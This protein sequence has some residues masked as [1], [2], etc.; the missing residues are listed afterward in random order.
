MLKAL[1]K[2]Q[3]LEL[4]TFY[5]IDRKKG[6]RRSKTGVIGMVI[7]FAMLFIFLGGAF[8]MM[9]NT[10]TVVLDTGMPWLYFALMSI[11]SVMLGV[12]G[13][14]FNTYSALW[15]AR[16][17]E[18][19]LSMPIKPSV[20]LGVRMIGV[21]MMAALY[22]GLV[23]I[24][25]LIARILAGRL[26]VGVVVGSLLM[27]LAV[28]M[29]VV[30]LTTLLGWAVAM[31]SARFK[32]QSWLTVLLSVVFMG[33]YYFVCAQS[34]QF[35]ESLVLNSLRVGEIVRSWLYPFYLIGTAAEGSVSSMMI[36]LG[37]ILVLMA[38]LWAVM[39]KTF[40]GI[41]GRGGESGSRAVY[42]ERRMH[43]ASPLWALI[44]KE[45]K[46]FTSSAGYMLNCGIGLVFMLALAVIAVL[47][48]DMVTGML[49]MAAAMIPG[50][51]GLLATLA[52]A[53][54]CLMVS[55]TYISAPSVSLEGK[56]LWIAQTLPV[57]G[58]LV[59]KAKIV[60]HLMIVELPALITT[61]VLAY[62]LRI[63]MATVVLMALNVSLFV[64]LSAAAGVALNLKMP[65]FNWT[66]EMYVVKQSIPVLIILFGGFVL[67]LG[68]AGSAFLLR[69]VLSGAAF[70]ACSLVVLAAAST[71]VLM[72]VKMRGSKI[73][74]KL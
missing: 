54:V 55:T 27:A 3:I 73:F 10:L 68:I 11:L 22:E 26:T 71:S 46:H 72:W 12:F 43:R 4:N 8:F 65:D 39:S 47:K 29:I 40:I 60:M 67:A 20:I 34:S 28:L 69:N 64:L 2:K 35:I 5:F 50:F 51:K 1:L 58:W 36:V 59:L 61:F 52:V 16:D 32:N 44:R 33:A 23:M 24:P 6:T 31:I 38:V 13:S 74:E 30:L 62:V 19:L 42:R 49:P 15:Q 63:E 21:V 18:A 48:Q 9:A 53:I 70:L 25:A 66:N 45:L 57:S 7:L 41:A 14:V 37:T 56:T 17:N